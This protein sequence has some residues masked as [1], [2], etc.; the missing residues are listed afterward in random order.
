MSQK[1]DISLTEGIKAVEPYLDRLVLAGGWVP[2]IYSRMYGSGL[3]R[4][5]I[6]TRDIDFVLS[7]HSFVDSLPPLDQT[8]IAA[9]FRHE[10]ASLENPPVVKYVKKLAEADIAEIEFITDAP[11]RSEGVVKIGSVNA[12]GLRYVGMLLDDTWEVDLHDL[13]FDLTA[14]VLIPRP[15]TYILHKSLIAGRRRHKEKVAKDLY[16]IFYTLE[17]FP[18]WHDNTIK[19]IRQFRNNHNKPATKALAFLS[20]YFADMDSRGIDYLLS[21]RPDTAFADMNDDQFRQ[22]ALATMS[23]LLEALR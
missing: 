11:G 22:Y 3:H 1:F 23:D 5:P 21:Q 18:D 15:S 10:F 13:G 14:T 12:Q 6:I 17:T 4:D 16:Y 7:R 9:G 2:R 8:I 19:S 20:R